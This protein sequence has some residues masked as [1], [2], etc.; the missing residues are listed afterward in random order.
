MYC[1]AHRLHGTPTGGDPNPLPETVSVRLALVPLKV[2]PVIVDPAARAT[3]AQATKII[4][5][6]A[7]G[8]RQK[9]TTA[10]TA[11]YVRYLVE[12]ATSSSRDGCCE[13]DIFEFPAVSLT[14]PSS[15]F[16]APGAIVKSRPFVRSFRSSIKPGLLT[17]TNRKSRDSSGFHRNRRALRRGLNGTGAPAGTT[18][19]GALLRKTATDAV[20][21][22]EV[23]VK[24]KRRGYQ[25]ARSIA[26]ARRGW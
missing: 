3:L 22:V 20:L 15:P 23:R 12:G 17:V 21:K 6:D 10:M 5:D 13:D 11:L 1:V 16:R 26:I 25:I 24:A 14:R 9:R 19:P 2:I 8:H 4:K 7:K 18:E